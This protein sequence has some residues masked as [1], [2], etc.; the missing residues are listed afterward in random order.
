MK[1]SR[2]WDCRD[3]TAG[4]QSTAGCGRNAVDIQKNE[5][6]RTDLDDG[7]FTQSRGI[8]ENCVLVLWRRFEE[9]ARHGADSIIG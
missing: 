4:L 7:G 3:R 9:V 5:L 1:S 6:G 8:D 2:R